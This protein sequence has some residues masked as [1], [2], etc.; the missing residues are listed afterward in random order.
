MLI[1]YLE[2]LDGE[3]WTGLVWLKIGTDGELL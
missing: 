2:R 3:K 1:I